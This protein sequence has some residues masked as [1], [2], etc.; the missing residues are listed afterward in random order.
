MSK[1]L[2]NGNPMKLILGFAVPLFFGF[3][4]QQFYNLVDTMIVGR[5]LG[6]DDLAAVGS[7]GSINFLVIGFCMGVCNGFSIPVSHKFGAQDY[8]GMRKYVANCTWL[9]IAFSVVMTVVTAL[10]CRNILEWMNTPANIIDG[11]YDYIFVI[12]LGIPTVYLYNIVSGVIRAIGDSKT[13]V[14]FLVLSSIINIVLDLYFIISLHWGVAGAA[15]ATVISQ[16]ISGVLCLI[17]MVKKFEILKIRGREWAPDAHMMLQLCNMGVPMGLQYSI[18]AIGSVVLQTAANT[19]GSAAVAAMT[20][21]GKIGNF[22][23]CPFDALGS[24]MATYGGQ[25]VGAGKLERLGKGLKSCVLI[26][27]GYAIIALLIAIFF[28]NPL[29]KLFIEDAD[30]DAVAQIIANVRLYLI[31]NTAFYFPLAL[32][33]IIR[34]LI[35]GMGFPRFAI[36]AGVFEMIA[37]SIAGFSLVPI[38]GF[39]GVCLGS[40]IA[41][42]M[43][44][45]FLIPAYFHVSKVLR[46][47]MGEN[48][49]PAGEQVASA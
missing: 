44:D 21:G 1:D 27:A 28:S 33:N 35:Q 13:P 36:L 39:T 34:F 25:N 41:W 48:T 2:T 23:A 15:W 49:E 32:V 4:F 24:T 9:G 43:A 31:L 10:L 26:G 8:V 47:R 11:A 6:V 22:L 40:P 29:A 7:T 16:G 17:Y 14:F 18:T 30:P 42:L 38:I 45:A 46:K 3:L 19:L 5:F 12:F 20:A 37:R